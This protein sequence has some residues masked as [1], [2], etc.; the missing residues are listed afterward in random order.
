MGGAG[1]VEAN[2]YLRIHPWRKRSA[3][4]A[5]EWLHH[6][7]LHPVSC[8]LL[9]NNARAGQ[10]IH[11]NPM[12]QGSLRGQAVTAKA[13]TSRSTRAERQTAS[14]TVSMITQTLAPF[15]EMH[16]TLLNSTWDKAIC[17]SVVGPPAFCQ[18]AFQ[19]VQV[20][21]CHQDKWKLL[22]CLSQLAYSLPELKSPQDL[23][24]HEILHS[25]WEVG[26]LW[27]WCYVYS[28]HEH[29]SQKETTAIFI[30]RTNL[31]GSNT[32]HN[33]E[34]LILPLQF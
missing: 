1:W 19:P 10:A 21:R 31:P 7:P 24:H 17:F 8:R 30:N 12:C 28:S 25:Y 18:A 16:G 27:K 23:H 34:P 3:G 15:T 5:S 20:G 32:F 6:G 29:L 33:V 4:Q 11:R 2:L 9:T 22:L 14:L 13:N 26:L